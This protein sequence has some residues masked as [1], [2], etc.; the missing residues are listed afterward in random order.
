MELTEEAAAD[1]TIVAIAG[2]LDTQTSSRFSDR[3]GELLHCGQPH[4]L[5]EVSRLNY[6]SSAGF[7]AL[8]IGAKGAA[9]KGGRLAVCG[10]T[11]PIR[12]VIELAGLH[13]VFETF[14]SRE[15]AL[16]KLAAG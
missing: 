2:R 10:V 5:I 4:L 14:A 11:A 12:R 7:R 6:I 13:D 3:L 1:V 9:E 8:L 15:E 16:A